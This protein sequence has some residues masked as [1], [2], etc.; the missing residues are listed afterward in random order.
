M[1]SSRQRWLSLGSLGVAFAIL[2][3]G[4]LTAC[5]DS[6]SNQS[7]PQPQASSDATCFQ[8][9]SAEDKAKLQEYARENGDT[10]QNAG[11]NA[12]GTESICVL[13]SDGRGGY[14]EHYYNSH[15]GFADYA[16]YAMLFGHSNALMT[17]GVISGDLS[18]ADAMMLSLLTNI[19]DDGR[20]YHPYTYG[21]GGWSRQGNNRTY[22]N[23]YNVT[24]VQYG[25]RPPTALKDKPT[26]PPGYGKKTLAPADPKKVQRG[27]L[28]NPGATSKVTP[29]KVDPGKMTP[30]KTT[31][32]P[33]PKY[34][35]PPV[36]K[37]TP[38]KTTR[39]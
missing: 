6:N 9:P 38:P 11:T 5:G 20:A 24:K 23:N 36:K 30:P 39:R 4:L 26:T 28:G 31:A 1:R 17:Y 25:S 19:G 29:P 2:T 32:K 16:M 27:G 8:T 35:P 10:T 34:T 22:I 13:E 18:V 3:G 14:E 37:Y 7:A 21:N 33:V 15:D 12:D